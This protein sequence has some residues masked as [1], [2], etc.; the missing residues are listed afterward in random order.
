MAKI[1]V[2]VTA[3][4]ISTLQNGDMKLTL[5]A[6]RNQ[7]HLIEPISEL[8]KLSND[9]KEQ[10][11]QATIGKYSIKRTLEA[12]SYLWILCDKIAKAIRST[13]EEVYKTAIKAVGEF[14]IMLATDNSIDRIITNWSAKGLGWFAEKQEGSKVKDCTRLVLYYGSSIY[15]RKQMFRLTEYI[16]EEAKALGIETRTPQQIAEMLK[17]IKE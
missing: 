5:T 16:I 3:V 8:T 6:P 10:L 13:K 14:D 7:R 12:N 1:D 9:T 2:I 4:E 15:D 17:Q 11:F